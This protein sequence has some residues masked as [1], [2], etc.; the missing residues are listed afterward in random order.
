MKEIVYELFKKTGD[1]KYYLLYSSLKKE[2]MIDE[3]R[4]R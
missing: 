2:E 3:D 1:I 4:K